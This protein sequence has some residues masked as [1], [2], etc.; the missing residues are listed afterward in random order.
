MTSFIKGNL[1]WFYLLIKD[2]IILTK[3][4]TPLNLFRLL[5]LPPD[6]QGS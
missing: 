5:T 3:Y 6:R 1:L 4:F 2:V